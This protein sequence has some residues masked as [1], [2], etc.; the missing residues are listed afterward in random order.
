MP[1]TSIPTCQAPQYNAIEQAPTPVVRQ[2][3][4]QLFGL[5]ARPVFSRLQSLDL[6]TCAP[7]DAMHL[8]FEN[9]VP[10]MIRHWFGEFKG[11]D[12]GTGN[13]W[14]SEEHCKVIGELTVKA[15]RTTPSY[16]VGTLPDIYKDRSLY[17]AEGYSYWFQ[18]LGAVLLKGRLPEKY[19]HMVLQ[20]EITYDELAELE[21]MVNQWISQYEE[22]Y[23]QYE[24]TRLPTCPLTIHALLHMPHTIRKAGPLWTSWAFVME[25]F[26]GHLLPAVKNR[27]R[28]YEHLDN[29]VQRRAQMQVVSLKYNLPSL[30]KP[31]IKYTRM[32]GEMISSR[33]KIYPDF[34]T[35]VLGTPVNSRV[36][37]TTQLTNQFTKYFGT[38]YQEMKLNGAALRA[39]I[40]LDT[41]V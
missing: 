34:P 4:A 37:I 27:T 19:Y 2:E 38:V 23:Y 18:H 36:P 3:L 33:E 30:A 10:N 15:V 21:E 20:F 24:A 7:Y 12:E 11:L 17:K 40:D 35:V 26:C 5:N 39:R 9:L 1:T 13:Y 28:P 29:Y 41:L 6:A 22:Y 14:I 32:H 25:R 31:A 16:F 8:L